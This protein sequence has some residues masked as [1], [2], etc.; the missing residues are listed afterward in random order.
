MASQTGRRAIDWNTAQR[1]GELVASSAKLGSPPTGARPRPHP[2]TRP[3][4][5]THEERPTNSAMTAPGRSAQALAYDFA[6]RVSEYTGLELPNELPP[7]EMVDRP[8]WIAA[9]LLTMRPTLDRVIERLSGEDTDEE[10]VAGADT[11]PD[12]PSGRSGW[13]ARLGPLSGPMRTA[14]GHLQT[15]SETASSSLRVASGHLLGAQ[16]GAVTGILSQRVLGQY[17]VSLV[18]E[19]VAPRLL[20]LEPN[21][22][23]TARNLDIDR[24]ELTAWVAIHE[25]TH[26]VQFAGVPWLRGHLGSLLEELLAGLQLASENDLSALL[27]RVRNGNLDFGKLVERARQ[28]ELLRLGL[29]EERWEIVERL[30]A[31]M[32]L[33]EGHAEHTMDAVGAD[34]LPSLP[35]LRAALTR[36]RATKGLPWRVLEK[37][38]GLELKMKQYEVGRRFCDV[39]VGEAGPRTLTIAWR[40]PEDL[41]SPAELN[42][43]ELWLARVHVAA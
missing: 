12:D 37:L 36:R 1:V 33:I 14:S 17:D 31:T 25:I 10:G 35:D 32:S 3:P 18:G 16:L 40:S 15:V 39:I 43:P 42:E 29:G 5:H 8:A 7:L 34:V 23:A 38:L 11:G 4:A 22:A 6:Q 2:P 19:P 41:P 24:G 28:G 20:L 21:L 30:Q 27:A 13:E 26:A 9:N